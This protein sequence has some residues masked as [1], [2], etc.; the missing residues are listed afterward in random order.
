MNRIIAL[1]SSGT[2]LVVPTR[3]PR[4]LF[5]ERLPVEVRCMIYEHVAIDT[6]HSIVNCLRPDVGPYPLTSL[7]RTSKRIRDDLDTWYHS[8]KQWMTCKDNKLYMTR[9]AHNTT[10]LVEWLLVQT[11]NPVTDY[12]YPR[13]DAD[14]HA[15][16]Y[17]ASG[18]SPK[19]GSLIVDFSIFQY[20]LG[21]RIP[22][23]SEKRQSNSPLD[24]SQFSLGL[25][26][27]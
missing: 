15:F 2:N 4:C 24:A 3:Y 25:E 12:L 8:N 9:N 19:V 11:A 23:L 22:P 20:P 16:C 21:A 17:P 5:L 26:A 18:E 13:A 14:W 7:R 10:Y 1:R 6:G 27:D